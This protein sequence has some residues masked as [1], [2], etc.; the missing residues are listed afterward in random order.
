M[1]E[2]SRDIIQTLPLLC[3]GVH[4]LKSSSQH[5]VP[6]SQLLFLFCCSLVIK[7]FIINRF[8]LRSITSYI[9]NTY[10]VSSLFQLFVE[11]V[12]Y[13][14]AYFVAWSA[15][16]R[17]QKRLESA[18]R[19]ISKDRCRE[20][21]SIR[22]YNTAQI[23]RRGIDKIRLAEEKSIS[24]DS[25]TTTLEQVQTRLHTYSRLFPHSNIITQWQ[26]TWLLQE[27][28]SPN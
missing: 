14:L 7:R 19:N 11:D 1:I 28:N 12:P 9:L 2:L 8:K 6:L 4:L 10:R 22:V 3:L 15:C 23:L 17:P 25:T 21:S 5:L 27:R 20:N 24:K 13:I 26:V 18:M 16:G